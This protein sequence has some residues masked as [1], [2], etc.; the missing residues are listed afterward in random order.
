MKLKLGPFENSRT[1]YSNQG[2]QTIIRDTFTKQIDHCQP[3]PIKEEE[4][5]EEKPQVEEIEQ[6]VKIPLK[7]KKKWGL[8]L[9]GKVITEIH[10]SLLMESESE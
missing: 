3:E 2:N 5:I 4:I 7:N 6:E 1:F 9:L 8:N 10:E